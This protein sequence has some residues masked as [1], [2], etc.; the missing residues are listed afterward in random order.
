MFARQETAEMTSC[1]LRQAIERAI[2]LARSEYKDVADVSFVHDELP[3]VR[4][5]GGEINQV[6]LNLL[7]NA[8]QAIACTAVRGVISVELRGRGD[9]VV[10]AIRDTGPGIPEHV[11]DHVFDQ[12]FTTKPVGAGTGQGLAIARA[13]VVEKHHGSLTFDT[14][15]AGT[16]FYVRIPLRADASL[17]A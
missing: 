5:H 12:F 9:E 11:R 8:S 4:C 1:D 13:I 7:V 15:P 3:P 17:A 6:V 14:G 10:I 2:T 16:C